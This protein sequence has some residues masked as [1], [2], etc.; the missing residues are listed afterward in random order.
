MIWI[1]GRSINAQAVIC[2]QILRMMRW[3]LFMMPWC[4]ASGIISEKSGLKSAVLGLSGGIDSAV[5]LVSGNT[6]T[7]SFK[8]VRV[9]LIAFT[10][11]LATFGDRC[12]RTCTKSGCAVTTL[13]ISG[14]YFTNICNHSN[15]VFKDMPA[16]ITEENIQARIRGNLLMAVV[17]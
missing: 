10:V 9:L 1:P 17:K 14:R 6:G 3:S 16:D 2:R 11:F 12:C 15:R 13:L 5:T 8:H 7:G 4:W